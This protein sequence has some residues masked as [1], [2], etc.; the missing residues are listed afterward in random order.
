MKVLLIQ[1]QKPKKSIGME[2]LYLDEPLA[3]E[4]LAADLRQS[5]AIKILDMR[6][7]R[8]LTRELAGFQPDIVGVTGYTIHVPAIKAI[9]QQVKQL[10]PEV[11]TI[12]GGHH[13]TIAP[14]DFMH[15]GIDIIVIGDGVPTL[16]EIVQKVEKREDYRLVKGIA[17][18]ENGRLCRTESRPITG[19]DDFPLPDRS[20]T[21]RYRKRYFSEWIRSAA[22][23]RTSRGCPF[24]C[25]F[26]AQWKISGGK[27]FTRSVESIVDELKQI[28][29]S[30]VFFADDESFVDGRR[31]SRLAEM[32]EA[33]GIKKSYT[34]YARVDTVVRNP[35]LLEQWK[36]I[37]LD[38]VGL[39]LEFCA[40]EDL[41]YVGKG[42][43][44]ELNKQAVEILRSLGIRPSLFLMVRPDYDELSFKAFVSYVRELSFDVAKFTV[45]TPLPGTDLYEQEKGRMLNVDFEYFDLVHT[46]LPT[47]LSLKEFYRQ[48]YQLYQNSIPMNKYRYLRN[49]P[50]NR[51]IALLWNN[52]RT[53]SRIKNLYKDY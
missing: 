49:Y 36:R 21:K 20:V 25:S 1:P 44:P 23:I 39:G 35:Q 11:L 2:H 30:L 28:E 7:D 40:Q 34:A 43:T 5:C 15:S 3:L 9:C 41:D 42:T 27:Y 12:A 10:Q 50:I 38:T 48:L 33:E 8:N 47:K 45:L 22:S 17:F 26:C 37:G 31:M 6:L 24:R 18:F 51:M 13:A 29:E 4:Y 16:K 53:M 19:L 46:V 52:Y 32:I 14:Q